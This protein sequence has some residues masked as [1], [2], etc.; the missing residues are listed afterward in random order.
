MMERLRRGV[1]HALREAERLNQPPTMPA[2]PPS[3]PGLRHAL[4]IDREGQDAE[5]WAGTAAGAMSETPPPAPP[6][7]LARSRELRAIL[8]S[9]A[10]LRH[11]FLLREVLGP[12]RAL[13]DPRGDGR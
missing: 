6:L 8:H 4:P 13:Q 10:A 5:P 7:P 3:P 11:A 9:R 2:R 12:P 1:E